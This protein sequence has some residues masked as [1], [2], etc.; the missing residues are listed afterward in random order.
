MFVLGLVLEN[1]SWGGEKIRLELMKKG[2]CVESKKKCVE[3]KKQAKKYIEENSLN[4]KSVRYEFEKPDDTWCIDFKYIPFCGRYL[5]LFKLI[6]DKSR[7]DIAFSLVENATTQA[8]IDL[9]EKGMKITGS[10]PY[11]LKS[12]R[13]SQF[14]N[15]FSRYLNDINIYHLKSIP[16]YAKCNAKVEYRFRIVEAEICSKIRTECMTK[17]EVINEIAHESYR[18]NFV[19]PHLSLGGATPAEEYY[20]LGEEIREKIRSFY[21]RERKGKKM[22]TPLYKTAHVSDYI[23]GA[24]CNQNVKI[25]I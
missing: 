25:K 12:D 5:Y 18:H 19:D 23:P 13:G 8:A 24:T 11:I 4:K 10:K 2:L 20:G 7:F 6:D 16:Y 21:S 9:I 1:P 15:E 17:K 22:R 3:L 14:K